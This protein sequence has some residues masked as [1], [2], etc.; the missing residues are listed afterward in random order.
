[1]QYLFVEKWDERERTVISETFELYVQ[2]RG[3]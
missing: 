2:N 3:F 1:M